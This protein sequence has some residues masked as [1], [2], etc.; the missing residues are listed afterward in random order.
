MSLKSRTHEAVDPVSMSDLVTWWEEVEREWN[1]VITIEMTIAG[2]APP[3]RVSIICRACKPSLDPH[4]P[5]E[6]QTR[7]SWPTAGHKTVLGAMWYLVR[8]VEL[9]LEAAA[10][11]DVFSSGDKTDK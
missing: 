11:L 9:Q 4:A 5:P 7:L 1:R 8:Q 10:A 6:A 3:K 2:I